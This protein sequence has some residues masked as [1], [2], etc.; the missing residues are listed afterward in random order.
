MKSMSFKKLKQSSVG[1]VLAIAAGV[2]VSGQALAQASCDGG[3]MLSQAQTSVQAPS[4]RSQLQ[5]VE[6]AGLPKK[7]W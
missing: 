2:L 3:E 7:F 6:L 5:P 4:I 1:A